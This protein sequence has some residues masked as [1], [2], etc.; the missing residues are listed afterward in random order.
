MASNNFESF[1]TERRCS[2]DPSARYTNRA[3]RTV[4]AIVVSSA[5]P[6]CRTIKGRAVTPSDSRYAAAR[7]AARSG[8]SNAAAVGR[9]TTSSVPDVASS[10]ASNSR[11]P[12]LHSP[13]PMRANVPTPRT[14]PLA[15]G[16]GAL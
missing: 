12:S 16:I 9:T 4:S 13:P 10:S 14:A 15:T 11:Q 8:C 6:R 1:N 2:G 5:S 7:S 3:L